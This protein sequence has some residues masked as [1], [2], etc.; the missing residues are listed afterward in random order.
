[1]YLAYTLYLLLN[2]TNDDLDRWEP[3]R[4]LTTGKPHW[5]LRLAGSH[6]KL[7]AGDNL[8]LFMKTLQSSRDNVCVQV[9]LPCLVF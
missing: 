3:E 1:M 4:D 8:T 5:K 6:R 9:W 7:P 2:D